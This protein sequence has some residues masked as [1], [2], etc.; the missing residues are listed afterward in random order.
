MLDPKLEKALNQAVESAQLKG[1]EFVSLEHI[2]LS[3][4]ENND[5]AKEI[6]SACGAD[7]KALAQAL[8]KHINETCPVVPEKDRQRQSDW[9]PELT[10]AFHR[11]LQRSAIQVQSAGRAQVSSGHVLVALYHEEESFARFILEQ[12][13][14]NQFDVIN[15][16]SHGIQKYEN[17]N[18]E[19]EDETDYEIDGLP[20]DSSKTKGSALKSFCVN[21]ND[22]VEKGKTDPLIG[23]EAVIERAIQVLSRRTKNNPLFVGEAGVGKTALADGLA[24]KVV[25]GDVPDSLK[26]AVIYSLDMGALLAGTKYRGDFEER[27]KA[28]LKELEKEDHPIL[29]VD[30]IHTM[31]GAGGTSGG[32]MDASNLLKPSLADGTLSC[33]GSTTYKEFRNHFE[34]D[35]ALARRFQK[36]DVREP[37]VEESVEILEGL[38]SRYEEHHNVKYSKAAVRAAVELS[39]KHITS[40]FL[41]DKAIDVMDEVGAAVR[42]QSGRDQKTKNIAVKDIEKV[43]ASMAQIPTK[44]VS[45]SDRSKL[46]NLDSDLKAKIFGQDGAIEKLVH[47]IKLARTGLGRENKPIGSYLFAGPTGVGKTEVSKQL[48]ENLNVSFLRYDMSEYMEKHSV[49]RLVG[50]P[51]GYV[52]YEE[53]GLLTDAVTK[54]PYSVVLMDEIEKAHPDLI[55]ILL[56]VMD[57][58]K[59]TD[60]NGKVADFTNVI[61]IMTSNAGAHEAAKGGMGI[62][63]GEG[64]AQSMEAIKRMFRPEFLNRLD[65]VVEFKNLPKPVLLKVVEKFVSE[66]QLQLEEKKIELSVTKSVIEKLFEIGHQ[67]QYGARPFARTVDQEIKI[68]LVDEI[69]FGKL[70]KGGRVKVSTDNNKLHFEI[71]SAEDLKEQKKIGAKER[72]ALLGKS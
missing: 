50:A 46:Q 48:A 8:Q 12:L 43:V 54:N 69:L 36:I 5:D 32:A 52:G 34:K 47:S 66:L 67:P 71:R 61:L 3:L 13:G 29:F 21:L 27:I 62:N 2:L 38:K 42:I 19:N 59:L 64:S 58:G 4:A 16:I 70:T 22:K 23:R 18:D 26:D 57:N 56:Q 28:V 30:E 51:P 68:P 11:L 14:V 7:L 41:P 40:R 9:K 33:M 55:N 39:A 65:A 35:R 6:L 44:S 31:I 24:Q 25:E 45:S 15:Y 10:L 1:H 49:S 72:P 60:S 37:S 17:P 53:G 63:P 20:K